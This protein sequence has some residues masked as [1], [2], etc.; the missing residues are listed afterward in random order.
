MDKNELF[1]LEWYEPE[2]NAP[3]DLPLAESS[4]RAGFPS[5]ADDHIEGRLDL[6][7]L[8]VTHPDATFYARVEGDSM[9]DECV[10]DGDLLVVDKSLDPQ[11]GNLVVSY[12]D[13]EFTLKR[14]RL[15]DDKILLVPANKKYPAIEIDPQSDFRIWG[16]VRYVVK[17]M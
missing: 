6:T 8:V 12:I 9:K 1:H 4:V 5:P 13:G 10:E 17:K 16:V 14:I 2:I 7:R 3:T 15:T 11:D